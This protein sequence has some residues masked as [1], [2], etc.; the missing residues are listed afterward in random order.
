LSLQ[1]GLI[2]T[3]TPF[4]TGRD[5]TL[6]TKER[7]FDSGAIGLHIPYSKNRSLPTFSAMHDGV[8]KIGSPVQITRCRGNVILEMEGQDATEK[9]LG[10]L[11]GSDRISKGTNFYF[12]L[13]S[14][15]NRVRQHVVLFFRPRQTQLLKEVKSIHKITSGDP[16][17]GSIAID[18]DKDLIP[19][20]YGQVRTRFNSVSL[21]AFFADFH[22][23]KVKRLEPSK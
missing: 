3:S 11:K 7:I 6:F 4:V 10:L 1:I 8:V 20:L 5:I 23:R 9:L 17:K 12:A 19:K 16:A 14:T 18:T 22:D 13:L 15:D 21:I 2:G